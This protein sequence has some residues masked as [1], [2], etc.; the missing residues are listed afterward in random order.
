MTPPLIVP[1][2]IDQ[3]RSMIPSRLTFAEATQLE[4]QTQQCN[5][6]NLQSQFNFRR[7]ISI[8]IADSAINIDFAED[9]KSYNSDAFNT[10]LGT[11][12]AGWQKE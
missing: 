11:I 6:S 12:V 8:S 4:G 3:Q 2:Q 9:G 10:G 7:R 5:Q 1:L